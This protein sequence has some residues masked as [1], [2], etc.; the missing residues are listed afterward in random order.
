MAGGQRTVLA[1]A[2]PGD[3]GLNVL[4]CTACLHEERGETALLPIAARRWTR[5]RRGEPDR[6]AESTITAAVAAVAARVSAWAGPEPAGIDS[7]CATGAGIRRSI[8][9]GE[10]SAGTAVGVGSPLRGRLSNQRTGESGV[11]EARV[12]ARRDSQRA[13]RS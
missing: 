9:A 11:V 6:R 4:R 2:T 7:L 8:G 3:A 12:M 1:G 13:R 10:T 5:A